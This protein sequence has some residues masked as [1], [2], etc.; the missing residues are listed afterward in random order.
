MNRDSL[1][2]RGKSI[3]DNEW[4]YGGIYINEVD[5]YYIIPTI[6]VLVEEE[7]HSHE[8]YPK[9][10]EVKKETVGQCI[11]M[12][13]TKTWDLIYEG[14]IW[15]DSAGRMLCVVWHNYS[16][17]VKSV[18]SN[19]IRGNIAEWIDEDTEIIGNVNENPEL[20]KSD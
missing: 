17:C 19:V 6:S 14:D 3:N 2:F 7:T 11:G 16:W 20:M 13:E 18:K 15:M 12:A 5:Q 8:L 1:I 4:V 10:I 9:F